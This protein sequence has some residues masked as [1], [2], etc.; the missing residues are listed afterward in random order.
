[1]TAQTLLMNGSFVGK[2]FYEEPPGTFSRGHLLISAPDLTSAK[3]DPGLG[4]WFCDIADHERLTWSEKV[5][6]LFGLSAGAPITRDWAVACYGEASKNALERV[7]R[8]ALSRGFGF[9]LDAAITPAGGSSRRIRVLAVPIMA[10]GR[11]VGL[12]GLT[13]A[14]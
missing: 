3:N 4:Y 14:L 13:R 6:E 8:Y 9:I 5:Y 1:M 2:L 10:A 7:R 12:H 11:V